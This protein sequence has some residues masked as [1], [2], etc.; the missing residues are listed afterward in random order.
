MKTGC[1]K[2]LPRGLWLEIHG[3]TSHYVTNLV[4][5]EW[6]VQYCSLSQKMLCCHSLSRSM[7]CCLLDVVPPQGNVLRRH[8]AGLPVQRCNVC[9]PVH[10]HPFLQCSTVIARTGAT[11]CL[12]AVAVSAEL[13]Q[14][15][16]A[17][18]ASVV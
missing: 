17:A 3:Q 7:F 14:E 6:Q 13:P 8:I 12:T 9:V 15:T 10:M 16:A 4:Q 11:G 2:A 18:P 1:Y 5:Q